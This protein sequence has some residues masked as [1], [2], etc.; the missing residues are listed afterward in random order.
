[1]ENQNIINKLIDIKIQISK[2]G[3]EYLETKIPVDLSDVG[4]TLKP[5]IEIGHSLDNSIKKLSYEVIP[6]S[7][8][9]Q[10]CLKS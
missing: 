2:L 8:P 10:N 4:L 6:G 1:M 5:F 7:I 9:K 3:I